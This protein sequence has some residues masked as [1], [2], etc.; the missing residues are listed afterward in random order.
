MQFEFFATL[1]TCFPSGSRRNSDVDVDP[2]KQNKTSIVLIPEASI[3]FLDMTLRTRTCSTLCLPSLTL[4][5][6]ACQKY[7]EHCYRV[8]VGSL[9]GDTGGT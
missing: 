5:Q 4:E 2:K 8:L 1:S 3:G 7:G 9:R 6:I